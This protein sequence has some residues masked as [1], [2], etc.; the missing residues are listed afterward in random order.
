MINK[1]GD[2]YNLDLSSDSAT[3]V[4]EI[5]KSQVCHHYIPNTSCSILIDDNEIATESQ[6]QYMHNQHN[7]DSNPQWVCCNKCFM[8]L[9]VSVNDYLRLQQEFPGHIPQSIDITC[10]KCVEN[11]NLCDL[12]NK[13]QYEVAQQNELVNK[14]QCEA[15]K[16]NDR[17][18]QLHQINN[19]EQELDKT[20]YNLNKEGIITDE[21]NYFNTDNFCTLT[22]PISVENI[23]TTNKDDEIEV[24]KT[25]QSPQKVSEIETPKTNKS[26]VA[27]NT[28]T[29]V[30]QELE[31]GSDVIFI[32][33]EN[34]KDVHLNRV[35]NP[36]KI[37][38]TRACVADLA[39]TADFF[40]QSLDFEAKAIIL[41]VPT[42]EI[43]ETKSEK[44]RSSYVNNIKYLQE[45]CINFSLSG[46]IPYPSMSNESFSR[47]CA[48]NRWLA[49]MSR[50]MGFHFI[51]NFSNFW[52]KR[53]LF[54]QNS[55]RLN[56]L[57]QTTLLYNITRY[58]YTY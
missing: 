46:P 15:T 39:E 27:D 58:A 12:V 54:E 29:K 22:S 56:I 8:Y 23:Q 42:V 18:K 16:Q 21:I 30:H 28:Q 5:T 19:Y 37:A 44:L 26:S 3:T 2:N 50:K 24:P 35:A 31:N 10:L 13:L 9:S 36:F 34:I 7:I 53:Q 47:V 57:G 40:M 45:R 6:Y 32:G 48:I 1:V 38:R 55:N 20:I 11:A 4:G 43:K 33:D 51:D 52:G 25:R 17:L 49:N 41:H 14:L